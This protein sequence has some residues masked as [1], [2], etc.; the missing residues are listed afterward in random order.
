MLLD[1]C[2]YFSA[3]SY[4]PRFCRKCNFFSSCLIRFMRAKN[5]FMAC[6]TLW[7]RRKLKVS[8]VLP[9]VNGCGYTNRTFTVSKSHAGR[10]SAPVRR[11]DSGVFGGLHA[12][13]QELM[14]QVLP[15]VV[16]WLGDG[17]S[18]ALAVMVCDVLLTVNTGGFT[19]AQ[20]VGL[21]RPAVHGC[22]KKRFKQQN[23]A[24]TVPWR[25]AFH[26]SLSCHSGLKSSHVE[27]LW[28]YIVHI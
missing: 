15:A 19:N 3:S 20:W 1:N 14:L 23:K 21:E 26:P 9:E 25:N 22:L 6:W 2:S 13:R 27:G 7:C 24:Y 10:E 12:W 16:L 17:F 11:G 8:G 28:S 4:T 18:R 5:G